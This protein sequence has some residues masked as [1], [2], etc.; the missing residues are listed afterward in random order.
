VYLKLEKYWLINNYKNKC[1]LKD[2][3]VI[4]KFLRN[5]KI[6]EINIFFLTH[7]IWNFSK[8]EYIYDIQKFKIT[9]H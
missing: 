3:N 8:I 1:F 6:F 9:H 4:F 5:F 2:L 7:E